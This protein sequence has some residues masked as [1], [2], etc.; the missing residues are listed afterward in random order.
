MATEFI[1][2]RNAELDA[3]KVLPRTAL[4]YLAG[5][6]AVE[7]DGPAEPQ[8]DAQLP[9]PAGDPEV[10]AAPQPDAQPTAAP[11]PDEPTGE[12]AAPD[13]PVTPGS[14]PVGRPTRKPKES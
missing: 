14:T 2:A 10:P 9:T 8:R 1:R 3:E 4:P 7:P 12:T 6:E 11:T 13:E 5:W